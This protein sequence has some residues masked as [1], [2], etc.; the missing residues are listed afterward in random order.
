MINFK[1]AWERYIENYC[2]V[3]NT[4]YVNVSAALSNAGNGGGGSAY[5]FPSDRRVRKRYELRYYQWIPYI[6]SLQAVLCFAPKLIFKVL[7]SFSG[8]AFCWLVKIEGNSVT[9]RI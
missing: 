1:G 4:Y 5:H 8:R 2:F 6:L 7:Y 9:N 3:E